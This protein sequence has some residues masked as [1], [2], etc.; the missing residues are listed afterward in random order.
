MT[1]SGDRAETT[2]F[3]RMADPAIHSSGL[4][5]RIAVAAI[6][7]SAL[8]LGISSGIGLLTG[9]PNAVVGAFLAV[10]RPDNSVGW[11]LLALALAFG[12]AFATVPATAAQ[13]MVGGATPA[14]T[15]IA[16][17]SGS[18]GGAIIDLFLVIAIVF[19]G[20]RLPTGHWGRVCRLALAS[21][22]LLAVASLFAPTI[23]VTVAGTAVGVDVPNPL[24]IFPGSPLW[25][26]VY[27]G[28]VLSLVLMAAG[29]G[30]LVI[31]LRRARAIERAQLRW[32]VWSMAC[33]VAGGIAVVAGNVFLDNRVEWLVWIP[34]L[35]AFPLPPIA[36][37]IAVL[38]YRLYEIDR[39]ISRTISWVAISAV[40]AG[41]FVAV[42]LAIQA[43]LTQVTSSNT[44]AVAA[45]TL[46]VAALFQP[47]RRRVQAR[48]DRRF[49]RARYDAQMIVA[50]F[51]GR[52]RDEVDLGQLELEIFATVAHTVQPSA[53][54]LWLRR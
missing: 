52:L 7:V 2:G 36:I 4:P 49:N 11:L 16:V 22:V 19:P 39:L 30:S 27:A 37:G 20:G 31:R 17:L 47:L 5:A 18:G 53:S 34:V 14:A 10:R 46:V 33:I 13:L 42:I 29:V 12:V 44:F 45:S 15:A 3:A 1:V 48:V 51:A 43:A 25:F 41:V 38:R 40:L 28:T 9:A 35:I 32:L 24:A 26:V 23:T 6:V 8:L 50:A 21:V 54:S